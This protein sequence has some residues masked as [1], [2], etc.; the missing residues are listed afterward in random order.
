MT[1][2]GTKARVWLYEKGDGHFS[3]LFGESKLGE[4][5]EYIEA[6]SNT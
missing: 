3:P 4:R 1:M 6:N 5:K 2:F